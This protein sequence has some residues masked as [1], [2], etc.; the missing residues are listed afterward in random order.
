MKR[1]LVDNKRIIVGSAIFVFVVL[2]GGWLLVQASKTSGVDEVSKSRQSSANAVEGSKTSRNKKSRGISATNTTVNKSGGSA[3]S[4]LPGGSFSTQNLIWEEDFTRYGSSTPSSARWNIADSTLPIY[5]N[6]AQVYQPG[7]NTVR[8]ADGALSLQALRQGNGIVSGRI[9][10]RNKLSI[11]VNTRLEA[12]IKLPIG[13]GTW[14]AFWLLS[15][16]QPHTSAQKPT[17]AK[18]EEDRFYM[19]DGEIDIMEAYGTYSSMVE[20]TLHTY[21]QSV[22]KDYKLS[23]PSGWH[24]YWMEWRSDTLILGVDATTLLTYKKDGKGPSGWPLTEDNKYYVILNLAMGGSGG[25]PIVSA[26]S[27]RWQM[28]VSRIAAYKL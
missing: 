6:E 7:Q 3:S 27:D 15:Q 22:E 8:V 21:D 19:W 2:I 12:R 23:D 25:G 13:K 1:R 16:N 10:T 28:D 4:T 17:A 14:P 18:W 20:A 26:S 9:D 24:T 11:G 5:N